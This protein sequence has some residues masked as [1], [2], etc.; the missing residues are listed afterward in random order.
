MTTTPDEKTG[1]FMSDFFV[2]YPN[3]RGRIGLQLRSMGDVLTNIVNFTITA[4]IAPPIPTITSFTP[5]TAPAGSTITITG[6]NFTGATAVRISGIPVAS[7]TVVSPTQITV[8]LPANAASGVISVTTPSGTATS[9]N[10]FTL[11]LPAPTITSFT[12][13][14][15][16]AGTRIVV[17]GT[18]F[19]DAA[20]EGIIQSVSI[21]GADAPL[22]GTQSAT[23]M[24]VV[25]PS[26]ARTG[27]IVVVTSGGTA[28]SST[29]F[30]VQTG[31]GV[32]LGFAELPVRV[33]PSPA[34]SLLNIETSLQAA[35]VV[36]VQI[37]S[38]SGTTLLTRESRVNAGA[39]RTSLDVSGLASG[40]YFVRVQAGSA[41]WVEKIV[42]Q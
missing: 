33:F 19:R 24:A 21:G 26:G 25:V 28:T 10:A 35:S 23:Q 17:T 5:T 39:Y 11:L 38:A 32:P 16:A 3:Y 1:S 7:F 37:V 8:T 6:T 29:D 18:N 14:M 4:P 2:R 30:T 12:P 22:F 20:G 9:A 34:E 42:K 13:S 41:A 31:S 36:Q 27:R 40:V 15:G